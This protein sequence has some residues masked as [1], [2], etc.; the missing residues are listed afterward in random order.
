MEVKADYAFD[1]PY[2]FGGERFTALSV[3]VISDSSPRDAQGRLV[4]SENSCNIVKVSRGATN[5]VGDNWVSP[6]TV[7]FS[8][9]Q[10]RFSDPRVLRAQEIARSQVRAGVVRKIKNNNSGSLGVTI[11]QAGQAFRMY[12]GV[13]RRAIGI[14]DGALVFLAELQ[15]AKTRRQMRKVLRK[16]SVGAAGYTLEGMFGWAPL[17]ADYQSCLETLSDPWPP[18]S[19]VSVKKPWKVGRE[20]DVSNVGPDQIV[21]A[22]DA[23]GHEAFTARV[24]ITNPNLWLANKVGLV[25]LPGV[26][27]DIIPWSFLVNMFTNMGSVVNQMTDLAGV[28]LHGTSLTTRIESNLSVEIFRDMRPYALP[29]SIG[30]ANG[31]EW[32]K[33]YS[34]SLGEPLPLITPY[35]RFPDWNLGASMILGSLLVQ[36]TETLQRAIERNQWLKTSKYLL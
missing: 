5:F 26:L 28:T 11:A 12:N 35:I 24:E 14:V 6:P 29:S 1:R 17:W 21:V 16:G 15:K 30:T 13:L 34:R 23:D 36:K 8:G 33:R 9:Y 18:S 32:Q 19:R 7:G 10:T 22:W 4:L 25:N 3:L 20:T 31:N 27:W 2:P